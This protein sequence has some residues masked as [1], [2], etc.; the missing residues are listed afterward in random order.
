MKSIENMQ[1]TRTQAV[2]ARQRFE[3]LLSV[4]SRHCERARSRQRSENDSS[5]HITR[6][7]HDE[8]HRQAKFEPHLRSNVLTAYERPVIERYPVRSILL[9]SFSMSISFSCHAD[10][11]MSS[12]DVG[13]SVSVP[14][15]TPPRSPG[16]SNLGRMAIDDWA[17]YA[18][19]HPPLLSADGYDF[20]DAD[21]SGGGRARSPPVGN[22]Y[23]GPQGN[24]NRTASRA[25]HA[26]HHEEPSRAVT[27]HGTVCETIQNQ[28]IVNTPAVTEDVVMGPA[29]IIT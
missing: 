26:L 12:Q 5:A 20:L 25:M 21:P 11:Y 17:H 4:S 9:E 6:K 27:A 8:H 7:A 13:A 14:R 2:R 22:G 19:Q 23:P 28:T 16:P 10:S 18:Q 24:L 3:E 1:Q 15:R 29:G